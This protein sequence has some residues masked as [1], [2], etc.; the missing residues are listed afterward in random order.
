MLRFKALFRKYCLCREGFRSGFEKFVNPYL[1]LACRLQGYFA[2][3]LAVMTLKSEI[4]E[5]LKG[6]H[7]QWIKLYFEWEYMT[8]NYLINFLFWHLA[9]KRTTIK[10]EFLA[11]FTFEVFGKCRYVAFYSLPTFSGPRRQ[12]ILL[13]YG[14]F[15]KCFR[16]RLIKERASVL[17]K[18]RYLNVTSKTLDNSRWTHNKWERER[19]HHKL[20]ECWELVNYPG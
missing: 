12:I 19:T 9:W 17:C 5:S 14:D 3:I 1:S 7:N 13:T 18:L 4:G 8:F 10:T 15:Q 2:L 16:Q 11:A 20:A 6:C